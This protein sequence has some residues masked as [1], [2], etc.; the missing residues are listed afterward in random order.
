VRRLDTG[1]CVARIEYVRGVQERGTLH[2][3]IDERRLHARQ[4]PRYAAFVDIA[5]QAAAVAAFQEY[6]LQHAV[7]D[8][9]CARFV[10]ARVDH[11]FSA[12]GLRARSPR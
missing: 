9:R 7:F 12:H 4:N 1:V 5:D 2:P 10:S 8:H 11:D 3:D 6:F